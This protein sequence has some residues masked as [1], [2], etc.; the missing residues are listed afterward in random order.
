MK[1]KN[2][3]RTA[4]TLTVIAAMT[5]TTGCQR[6][7]EED[8]NSELGPDNTLT[9]TYGFEMVTAGIYAMV[10]SEYNTWGERGAYMHGAACAY[11][12]LQIATD[13]IQSR[14]G[15]DSSL[16]PYDN[17]TIPTTE[18]FV[19]SY[20]RW[21][22]TVIA[23]CNLVLEYA[24]KNENWDF[25]GDKE[26]FQAEA[27]FFRAYAYRTLVYLYGDVPYVDAIQEEFKLDFTRTPKAEVLGHMVDDLKFATENLPEDPDA[28]GFRQGRLTRWAA[29]HLLS[30]IYL[31]QKNY[32]NARDAALE[33]IDSGKYELMKTRFGVSAKEDGDVYHDMFLENNQNRTSGN[34]ESIFVLQFDFESA[35]AS[36]GAGGS[37]SDDWT[38]RGLCPNYAAITGFQIC[39][40]LGG[41][42]VGQVVPMKW[43]IG[44]DG[45]NASAL[46]TDHKGVARPANGI[47]D[48]G[49]MRNSKHNI[50]RDWW[51]NDSANEGL[52]K[53]RCAITDGTWITN[54]H[55][56][57][58]Y[59][60]LFSGRAE[61]LSSTGGYKD[62]IKFRLAE[63]YL[64][65]AEAY[66]G[67]NDAG[68]AADAVNEVRK[69][70]NAPEV[71]AADM[72]MDYLLDERIRELTGEEIRRF[73]LVRTGTYV[74]RVKAH[75]EKLADIVDEHNALWPVP[76]EIIDANRG[77]EFPQNPGY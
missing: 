37:P 51:F 67:L 56:F 9:S 75:N 41:R 34:R 77:A 43:W 24:D 74:E 62:R 6:F 39:D 40:T 59:T 18:R 20:W 12:C 15:T 10:R 29:W 22:Y 73:T 7:L 25:P 61:N 19:R 64:L 68:K 53:S 32:S 14:N 33:V 76:Q 31:I 13:I 70:A 45:T 48:A 23:T 8:M 16:T 35:N 60:K 49:D 66:L 44:T 38:R 58:S 3:F 65:L 17:L 69:R 50:K 63:T 27:R 54:G 72:D 21:G 26:R 11:E 71:T 5:A 52:Y 2:I 4:V 28:N 46:G 1:M 42:G 55:L 30:E 36:G 57:P 47:W